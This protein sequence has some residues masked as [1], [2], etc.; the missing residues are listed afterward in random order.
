MKFQALLSLGWA[1]ALLLM[2]ACDRKNGPQAGQPAGTAAAPQTPPGADFPGGVGKVLESM[3]SG[4]YTYV[5]LD[6]NGRKVWVAGPQTPVNVGDRVAVSPGTPMRGFKSATLDRTFDIIYFVSSIKVG[7]APATA[8]A[9]GAAAAPAG[10]PPVH[11]RSGVAARPVTGVTRAEGG[12]TVE[13]IF[14]GKEGLAGQEVRVRGQVVKINAGILGK[15][16]L[17]IQDGTGKDG[18]HDL[19][20]TTQATAIVG[21]VV[22]VR[23]KVA[24]NRDF[25]AGYTY[26]VMIEEATLEK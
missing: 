14:A 17:H 22:L 15:N 16:W 20:V 4:G 21:D 10:S 19:T 7:D 3:P 18:T 25:G 11:P 13:E 1:G 6:M 12:K 26:A 23:G 9:P 2:G 24:L 5:H 8:G